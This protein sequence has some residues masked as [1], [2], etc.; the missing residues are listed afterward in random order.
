MQ[1]ILFFTLL[2]LTSLQGKMDENPSPI[3]KTNQTK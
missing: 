1:R 2:L 3:L